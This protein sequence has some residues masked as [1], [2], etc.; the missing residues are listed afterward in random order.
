MPSLR[1]RFKK[2]A[3]ARVVFTAVRED[4]TATSSSIGPADR[5]GPVHDMTHYVVESSLGFKHGFLGLLAS[6]RNIED[7]NKGAKHW[8]PAEAVCAEAIAG[9]LSRE[10]MTG[11]H[12]SA[13]DFNWTTRD[14]LTRS[15]ISYSP[16][17]LTAEQLSAM[18]ADLAALRSRWDALAPNE[19]LELTFD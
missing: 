15:S 6:G 17:T 13:E 18:H 8:L 16:P 2:K 9:E 14:V 12:L 11:D 1:L 19:T 3:D 5:F 4:G 7:F 10:A